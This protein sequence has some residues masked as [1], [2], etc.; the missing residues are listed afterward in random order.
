MS[1]RLETYENSKSLC[2]T[3]GRSL[4]K[5][6]KDLDSETEYIYRTIHCGFLGRDVHINLEI[7][8]C[9]RYTPDEAEEKVK[10]RRKIR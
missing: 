10:V 4:C 1:S 8:E 9:N 3:C 5:R 2:K 6:E 7:I